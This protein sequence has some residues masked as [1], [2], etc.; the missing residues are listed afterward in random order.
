MRKTLCLTHQDIILLVIENSS[1]SVDGEGH[2]ADSGDT[3]V[4]LQ[5]ILHLQD[6]HLTRE[7]AVTL[8]NT[9]GSRT[10]EPCWLHRRS[11]LFSHTLANSTLSTGISLTSE[12]C[13]LTVCN[14]VI[15]PP[16]LHLP[17]ATSLPSSTSPPPP[18]FCH[19]CPPFFFLF[20]HSPPPLFPLSLLT[21]FRR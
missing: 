12:I 8:S 3:W 20:L 11:Q 2:G 9:R 14:A 13:R 7:R 5:L 19:L 6:R 15:L 16:L 17:S 1:I 4:P 10:G 21:F 18:P